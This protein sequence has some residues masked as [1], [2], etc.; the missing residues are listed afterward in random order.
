MTSDEREY[1]AAVLAGYLAVKGAPGKPRPFDRALALQLCRERIAIEVVLAAFNLAALRRTRRPASALPLPSIRSLAYFR[2]II[3]ELNAMPPSPE[4]I[5]YLS[6][7]AGSCPD[8][9][10]SL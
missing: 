3:D 8:F 1:V 2:P 4:Y 6:S 7:A 10:D 9:R 5:L